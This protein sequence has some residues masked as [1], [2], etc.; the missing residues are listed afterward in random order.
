VA[1]AVVVV[2]SHDGA[3]VART[4]T[5][6]SGNFQVTLPPGSYTVGGDQTAGFPIPPSPVAVTV[7]ATIQTDVDL[8]FDTGIR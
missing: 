6:A 2:R 4:R 7:V 5:D 8:L 1:D 3:E